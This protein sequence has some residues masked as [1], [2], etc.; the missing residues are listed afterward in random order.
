MLRSLQ[1]PLA[2]L[3]ELGVDVIPQRD[4]RGHMSDFQKVSYKNLGWGATNSWLWDGEYVDFRW[5][6]D[7]NASRKAAR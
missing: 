1:G 7:L 5:D 3:V 4:P 6:A 2:K